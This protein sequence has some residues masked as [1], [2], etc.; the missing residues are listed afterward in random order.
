MQMLSAALSGGGQLGWG[1]THICSPGLVPRGGKPEVP[2]AHTCVAHG[3][4]YSKAQLC[5][6]FSIH[7]ISWLSIFYSYS[8]PRHES[9][10]YYLHTVRGNLF[11]QQI[12]RG[13]L[14]GPRHQ[15]PKSEVQRKTLLPVLIH[16]PLINFKVVVGP[17]RGQYS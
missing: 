12:P 13:P 17:G 7:S 15:F 1:G 2:G 4:T 6:S 16:F 5:L 14:L 11:T 3:D 10:W 8:L 9:M